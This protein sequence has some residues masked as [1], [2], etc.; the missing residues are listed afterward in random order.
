MGNAGCISSTVLGGSGVVL[1]RVISP[2]IWV[3]SIVTPLKTLLITTPEPPSRSLLEDP[4]REMGS[5]CAV[6]ISEKLQVATVRVFFAFGGA[7]CRR[8][9]PIGPKVV[10]FW[11]YLIEF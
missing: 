8:V 2:L 1:S 4:G 3:I 5:T 9:I 11:D 7:G 10:P 6:S